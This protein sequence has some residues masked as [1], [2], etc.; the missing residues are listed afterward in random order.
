MLSGATDV[1]AIATLVESNPQTSVRFLPS[2]HAK[3]YVSDCREAVI[4]SANLTDN[5]LWRNFE[6]GVLIE[7]PGEVAKVRADMLSYGDLGSPITLPQLRAFAAVTQDLRS[8]RVR[9]EAGLRHKLRVEFDK[10]LDSMDEEVLRARAAGRSL[11]AIL[12]DAILYLLR[13]GPMKTPEIHAD[14]QRIHPDLCD[15]SIDRVINGVHF[16]KKWKHAVRNAQ[17]HLKERGKITRE[18]GK[19]MLVPRL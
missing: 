9:A 12:S 3:V 16:G 7:H 14:V 10:K 18:D 1:A 8:L 6:Y 5:G 17:S 15:D 19:W 13:D 11:Q 2:L 4:T